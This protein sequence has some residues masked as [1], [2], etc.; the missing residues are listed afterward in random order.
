MRKLSSQCS[1]EEYLLSDFFPQLGA[2]K[3]KNKSKNF[4]FNTAAEGCIEN[5]QI[6]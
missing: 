6:T 5:S 1:F 2:V 4:L 3:R